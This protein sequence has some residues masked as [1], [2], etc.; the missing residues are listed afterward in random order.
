MMN[1][2]FTFLRQNPDSFRIRFIGE[3]GIPYFRQALELAFR[4]C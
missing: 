3:L 2:T 1:G 4:G